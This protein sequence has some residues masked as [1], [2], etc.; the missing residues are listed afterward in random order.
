MAES[1]DNTVII[2]LTVGDDFVFL[3]PSNPTE[4]TDEVLCHEGFAIEPG[5]TFAGWTY[6]ELRMLGDGLHEIVPKTLAIAS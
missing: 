5:Q 2:D 4:A 6:Q 1:T 3:G